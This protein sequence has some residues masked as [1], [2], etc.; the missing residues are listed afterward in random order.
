MTALIV[1]TVIVCALAIAGVWAVHARRGRLASY[2]VL[3][4]FVVAMGWLTLG[5]GGIRSQVVQ[6]RSQGASEEFIKGMIERNRSTLP[7]RALLG[8][9]ISA[10]FACGFFAARISRSQDHPPEK[11]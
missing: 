1:S 10:L 9:T 3:A 2:V 11:P 7:S 5:I 6:M 8:F 4:L